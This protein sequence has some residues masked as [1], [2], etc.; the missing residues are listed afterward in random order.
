MAEWL[1]RGA[2]RFLSDPG[3][4]ISIN[5]ASAN[6]RVNPRF[7]LNIYPMQGIESLAYTLQYWICALSYADSMP[8]SSR[9]SRKQP[10]R[11][12]VTTPVTSYWP[13]LSF[14]VPYREQ[15]RYFELA[16]VFL[17]LDEK[18]FPSGKVIPFDSRGPGSS[19]RAA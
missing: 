16:D 13:D 17:A 11:K 5:S 3:V 4:K 7:A 10:K 9:K 1:L 15:Q 18:P 14:P 6:E 12:S 8:P 2:G 19:R